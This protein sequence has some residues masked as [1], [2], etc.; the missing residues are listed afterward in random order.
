MI[1]NLRST[2]HLANQNAPLGPRSILSIP[3]KAQWDSLAPTKVFCLIVSSIL[4]RVFLLY[5]SFFLSNEV[6][7]TD[8]EKDKRKYSLWIIEFI[9]LEN[10][11][12]ER[13]PV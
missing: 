9:C 12:P 5:I 11:F 4:G 7:A 10:V 1:T 3:L 13:Y 8:Q 2:D 6:I